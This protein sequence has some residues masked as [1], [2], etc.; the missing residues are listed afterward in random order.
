[1]LRL[2]HSHAVLSKHF[3]VWMFWIFLF[4]ATACLSQINANAAQGA[5]PYAVYNVGDIDNVNILNGNVFVK[6]PLLSYPQRGKDLTMNF[7]IYANDK[8]WY[9][10]NYQGGATYTGNWTGAAFTTGITPEPLVGAY[11]ARDQDLAFG[12]DTLTSTSTGGGEPYD[13]YTI[14]TTNNGFYAITGDGSKHYVGDIVYLRC[15]A[16]GSGSTRCREVRNQNSTQSAVPVRGL[17]GA[18]RHCQL[19]PSRCATSPIIAGSVGDEPVVRPRLG[20]L[21]VARSERPRFNSP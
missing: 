7:Y 18:Q 10:G 3:F 8:Q 4:P 6:I 19:D 12:V 11:V 2:L 20:R 17:A 21:P 9:I 5:S 15:Q 16:Q 1:M 13:Q 14:T